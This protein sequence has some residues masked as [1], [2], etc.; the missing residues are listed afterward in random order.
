MTKGALGRGL[1]IVALGFA[2]GIAGGFLYGSKLASR[3]D[4]EL[5]HAK[6]VEAEIVVLE[7]EAEDHCGLYLN[8][9]HDN[10]RSA[11]LTV[12]GHGPQFDIRGEF[13]EVEANVLGLP[14]FTLTEANGYLPR[15][16]L[17]VPANGDKGVVHVRG[18]GGE[19][20]LLLPGQ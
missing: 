12:S 13:G 7:C 19:T 1:L 18:K 14:R 11:A 5:V 8:H 17:Q 16:S 10:T 4:V 20:L 2:G 9:G 15:I 3:V 6:R